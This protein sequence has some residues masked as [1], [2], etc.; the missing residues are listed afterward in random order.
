M[1][2]LKTNTE[3]K[4]IIIIVAILIAYLLADKIYKYLENIKYKKRKSAAIKKVI[5]ESE[6]KKQTYTEEDLYSFGNYL[7][8]EKRFK[9]LGEK[10]KQINNTDLFNW[11][12]KE[13]EQAIV[14][15]YSEIKN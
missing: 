9:S 3:D 2:L 10:A 12:R 1:T 7:L 8:S 6:E 15:E 11:K 5:Q 13:I 4:L 14:N